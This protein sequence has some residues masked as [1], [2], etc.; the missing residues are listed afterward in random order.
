MKTWKTWNVAK[1]LHFTFLSTE[2]KKHDL[3]DIMSWSFLIGQFTKR[4]ISANFVSQSKLLNKFFF[5]CFVLFCFCFVFCFFVLFCFVLFCFVLFFFFALFRFVLFCLVFVF[6]FCFYFYYGVLFFFFFC[7]FKY[8][9]CEKGNIVLEFSY[10][11]I[12]E[13]RNS[14]K[15]CITKQI[16]KQV[17]SFV[18]FCF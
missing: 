6:D 11:A 12:H 8:H 9:Q 15:F 7:L 2:D 16:T 5:C 10:W 17:F 3:K 1:M 14:N 4:E 13:K 18:L